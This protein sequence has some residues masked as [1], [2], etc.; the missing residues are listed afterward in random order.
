MRKP[1]ESRVMDLPTAELACQRNRAASAKKGDMRIY[2]PEA[3]LPRCYISRNDAKFA[4][5]NDGVL[6][7]IMGGWT[8]GVSSG[9]SHRPW[10]SRP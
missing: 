4:V 2:L 1:D 3:T 6:R 7:V 10:T 8:E 9:W 5:L